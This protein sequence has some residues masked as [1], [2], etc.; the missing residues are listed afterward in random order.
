MGKAA[1]LPGHIE[2][3]IRGLINQ[4]GRDVQDLLSCLTTVLRVGR[5]VA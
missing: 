2:A 4:A 1:G 3:A 5:S